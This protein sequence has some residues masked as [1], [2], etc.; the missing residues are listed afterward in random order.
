MQQ[1]VGLVPLPV[2]VAA[3]QRA[4]VVAVHHAVGVEHGDYSEH[5]MFSKFC[6]FGRENVLE[7]AVQHVRRLGLSRMHPAS[8]EDAL[9]LTVVLQVL[10]QPLIEPQ[11]L[12]ARLQELL[13]VLF[14]ELFEVFG[15]GR[16]EK[17]LNLA[18][19]LLPLFRKSAGIVVLLAIGFAE[20]AGQ[21]VSQPQLLIVIKV[22]VYVFGDCN[23]WH[24]VPCE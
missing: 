15:D 23:Q 3:Q 9:L 12:W 21:M 18:V 1:P 13:F 19:G 24:W 5:E 8:E 2:Q 20:D 22:S 7:Q 16:L 6:C 4:P 11:E 17:S 10:H 14:P